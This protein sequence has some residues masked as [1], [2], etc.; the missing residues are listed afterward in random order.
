[1]AFWALTQ[2]EIRLLSIFYG[3]LLY[4]NP[5]LNIKQELPDNNLVWCHL[6]QTVALKS[7]DYIHHWLQNMFGI[8][9]F[10]YW[11]MLRERLAAKPCLFTAL[12]FLSLF[13]MWVICYCKT[14]LGH[15]VIPVSEN[16]DMIK[17]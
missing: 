14:P 9:L 16:S 2:L 1:M 17:K 10:F 11:C 6:L 8:Y 13:N 15:F 3:T 4:K 12:T 5:M 7:W